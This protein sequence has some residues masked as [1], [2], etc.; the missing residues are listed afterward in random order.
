MKKEDLQ[1]M[2]NTRFWRIILVMIVVS[3]PQVLF[4]VKYDLQNA[5]KPVTIKKAIALSFLLFLIS[6]LI[7]G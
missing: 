2:E 5:K 6:I 4:A 7:K 1:V 3:L